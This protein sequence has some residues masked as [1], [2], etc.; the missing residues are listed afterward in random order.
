M[1][2]TYQYYHDLIAESALKE[3]A[4][5]TM[6]RSPQAFEGSVQTLIDHVYGRYDAVQD[7][8]FE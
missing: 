6:L 2:A 7:Y 5:A 8:L 4:D 3:T 1:A